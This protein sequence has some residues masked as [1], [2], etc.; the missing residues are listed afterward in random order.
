M[1]TTSWSPP[2]STSG[3]PKVRCPDCGR[4]FDI[5]DSKIYDYTECALGCLVTGPWPKYTARVYV[6][7]VELLE[8]G[9]GVCVNVPA[10]AKLHHNFFGDN[11]ASSNAADNIALDPYSDTI[12]VITWDDDHQDWILSQHREH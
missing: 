6:D 3:V 8:C 2:P 10:L 12:Y 7:N 9:C 4:R 11:P 1:I 5:L